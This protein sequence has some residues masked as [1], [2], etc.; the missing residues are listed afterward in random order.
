MRMKF[1]YTLHVTLMNFGWKLSA[2]TF[3]HINFKYLNLCNF[4]CL[5]VMWLDLL[6]SPPFGMVK[7]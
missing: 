7:S 4:F 5:T 2:F 1:I 6:F 3:R